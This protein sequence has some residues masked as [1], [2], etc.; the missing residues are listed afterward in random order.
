MNFL[1]VCIRVFFPID[2]FESLSPTAIFYHLQIEIV[3]FLPPV[4]M[5]LIIFSCSIA[6][7]PIG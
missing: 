3:V 2:S 6:S 5:S 4:F 1:T 7:P